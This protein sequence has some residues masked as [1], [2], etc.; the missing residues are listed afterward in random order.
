LRFEQVSFA[1][2]VGEIV[3]KARNLGRFSDQ[4]VAEIVQCG[5]PSPL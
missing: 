2:N 1:V 4:P 5:E 3:A